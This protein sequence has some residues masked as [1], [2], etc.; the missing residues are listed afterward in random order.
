MRRQI[1]NGRCWPGSTGLDAAEIERLIE[2]RA[3][4]RR[5]KDFGEADRIRDQ[6][7]AEGVI[8]EDLPDRTRWRLAG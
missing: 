5:G 3:T 6:V 4:A 8:I 7:A 1:C 2:A